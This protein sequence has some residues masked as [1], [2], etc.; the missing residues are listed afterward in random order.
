[1]TWGRGG[2]VELS[3]PLFGLEHK[4]Q[5]RFLQSSEVSRHSPWAAA[6]AESDG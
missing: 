6:E 5:E 4:V 2:V 1:M 3:T